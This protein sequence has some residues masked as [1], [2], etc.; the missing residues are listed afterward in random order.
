MS[1]KN[2]FGGNFHLLSL[3]LALFVLLKMSILGHK[4]PLGQGASDKK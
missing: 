2:I 4:L 1:P 3:N